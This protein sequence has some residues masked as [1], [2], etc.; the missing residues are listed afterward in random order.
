MGVMGNAGDNLKIKNQ[1]SKTHLK[2]KRYRIP[3]LPIKLPSSLP[4]INSGQAL[5]KR[6][7]GKGEGI[8]H[9]EILHYP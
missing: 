7:R 4:S 3:A 8:P 6:E 2:D 9:P 1:I 5:L